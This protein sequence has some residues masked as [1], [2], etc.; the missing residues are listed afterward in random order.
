[1]SEKRDSKDERGVGNKRE[2]ENKKPNAGRAGQKSLSPTSEY[3]SVL[4]H[5]LTT[6]RALG[7]SPCPRNKGKEDNFVKT[8]FTDLERGLETWLSS[9]KNLQDLGFSS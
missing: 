9:W 6:Q 3:S 4:Q 7:P 5:V 1:M 2:E 8:C